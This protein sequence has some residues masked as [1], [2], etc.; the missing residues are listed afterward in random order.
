[1]VTQPVFIGVVSGTLILSLA[2][3]M[4]TVIQ[5]SKKKPGTPLIT[6]NGSN[7]GNPDREAEH[8]I[9]KKPPPRSLT[10]DDLE[11]ISRLP[12]QEIVLVYF[13]D[14]TR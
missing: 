8:L 1:M 14:T 2:L 11:H 4:W 13:P 9:V 3:L 10:E 5:C 6:S 7:A 12:S